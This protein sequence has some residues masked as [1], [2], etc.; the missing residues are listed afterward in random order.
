MRWGA[1]QP[2]EEVELMRRIQIFVATAIDLFV[3]SSI[4]NSALGFF[5]IGGVFSLVLVLDL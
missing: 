3:F 2:G 4:E 5:F 1:G